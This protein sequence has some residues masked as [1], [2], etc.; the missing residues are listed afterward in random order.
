M[1]HLKENKIINLAGVGSESGS[2]NSGS[3][4]FYLPIPAAARCKA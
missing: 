4:V 1:I 3:I 2:H